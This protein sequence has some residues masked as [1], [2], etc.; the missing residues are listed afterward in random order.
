MR[1]IC[2]LFVLLLLTGFNV[3]AQE[4]GNITVSTTGFRN[5]K[6]QA[7]VAIFNSELGFPSDMNH[8]LIAKT[9]EIENGMSTVAFTGVPAGKYAISAIHDEDRDM[10]FDTNWIFLP[11]EGWGTSNNTQGFF[12]PGNYRDSRFILDSPD[13][14]INIIIHY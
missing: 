5:D 9:A 8:A 2:F 1:K 12:G 7:L 13:A 10:H 14:T 6:G 4:S 11:A 3:F